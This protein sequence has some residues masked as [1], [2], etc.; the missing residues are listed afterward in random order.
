MP[1]KSTD[2]PAL[3]WDTANRHI[4]NARD[5]VNT[6]PVNERAEHDARITRAERSMARLRHPVPRAA[7]QA[8][9]SAQ[10][11]YQRVYRVAE[12]TLTLS[13][14]QRRSDEAR[15]IRQGIDAS[16]PMPPSPPPAPAAQPEPYVPRHIMS[17]WTNETQ[18]PQPPVAPS[19][20]S[21]AASFT[22]SHR[23]G[24]RQVVPSNWSQ[25]TASDR[26]PDLRY[27]DSDF[28]PQHRAKLSAFGQPSAPT[29]SSSRSRD[30]QAS[31]QYSEGPAM[32]HTS[33]G[34]GGSGP[35]TSSSGH[36]SHRSR[37][38]S[39]ASHASSQPK[40]S[41]KDKGKGRADPKRK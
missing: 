32:S 9:G 6:L 12:G 35:H 28:Q 31:S 11:T 5:V 33:H 22:S 15:G 18:E 14:E 16:R 41:S 40:A 34:S 13:E 7:S 38:S 25:Q 19:P 30:S 21:S 36:H 2:T 3:T 20:A 10:S 23:S 26:Q 8:L 39:S 29:L 27:G 24:S 4:V 1:P 17:P 37:H